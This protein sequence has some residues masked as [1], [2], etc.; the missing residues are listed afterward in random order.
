MKSTEFKLYTREEVA[1][2]CSRDDAWVIIKDKRTGVREGAIPSKGHGDDAAVAR[3][4][5]IMVSITRGALAE[6][7]IPG[8]PIYMG[9]RHEPASGMHA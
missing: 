5:L 4:G 9:Q 6:G 2:H 3:G 1:K 8:P 7:G